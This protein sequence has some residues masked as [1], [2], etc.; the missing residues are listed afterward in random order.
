MQEILSKIK[1]TVGVPLPQQ[2][3]YELRLDDSE[4]IWRPGFI[5]R[6]A[7]AGWDESS[8]Q[9]V[10]DEVETERLATRGEAI[11]RY[12]TRRKALA[13]R[14]FVYSDMDL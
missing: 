8:Q 2:V 1:D 13:K 12:E 5:V 7:R 10:W 3:F 14:G 4:E 6:E 9:V 11:A